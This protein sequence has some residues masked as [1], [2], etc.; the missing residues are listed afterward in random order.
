M[1][2]G[3]DL[4]RGHFGGPIWSARKEDI[5]ALQNGV[6]A[7]PCRSLPRALTPFCRPEFDSNYGPNY[8]AKVAQFF[9]ATVTVRYRKIVSSTGADFAVGENDFQPWS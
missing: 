3:G 8:P 7:K 2:V 9:A 6:K 5:P 4:E 1:R